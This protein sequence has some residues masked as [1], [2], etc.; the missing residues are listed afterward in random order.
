MSEE[1]QRDRHH[2]ELEE[3]GGLDSRALEELAAVEEELGVVL[4]P[5]ADHVLVKSNPRN[6]P[7]Q[8]LRQLLKNLSITHEGRKPLRFARS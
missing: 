4:E 8:E 2:L 3:E 5:G 6:L 7:E 1:E